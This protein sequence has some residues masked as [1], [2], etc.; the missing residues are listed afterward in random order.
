MTLH[1][2]DNRSS[3]KNL[4]ILLAI[5][6]LHAFWLLFSGLN[7]EASDDM[8]YIKNAIDLTRGSFTLTPHPFSNRFGAFVPLALYYKLFG[9]SPTTTLLAPM[10][11]SLILVATVFLVA[12]RIG[13]IHAAIWSAVLLA[14]NTNQLFF[15]LTVDDDI[16][17]STIMTVTAAWIFF[18]R[19]QG[20]GSAA[21]ARGA[22]VGIL[23]SL[24][25]LTKLS[26]TWMLP[27][28]IALLWHDLRHGRNRAFW[29][30]S[31]ISGT[32][33]GGMYLLVYKVITGDALYVMHGMQ[34][35]YDTNRHIGLP[36]VFKDKSLSQYMDRLTWEPVW[37]IAKRSGLAILLVLSLPALISLRCAGPGT[38]ALFPPGT[39]FWT[40]Y[41]FSVL[42]MFWFGTTSFSYY[43][44][45]G[46]SANYLLPTMGPLSLLAGV[47]LGRLHQAIDVTLDQTLIRR[48][49]FVLLLLLL[50]LALFQ[51]QI[52][53]YKKESLAA[54]MAVLLLTGA[55]MIRPLRLPA[56]ALLARGAVTVALLLFAILPQLALRNGEL[57]GEPMNRSERDLAQSF[58]SKI[59]RPTVI[60]TDRRSNKS[61]PYH[62]ALTLPSN[63]KLISYKNYAEIT[64]EPGTRYL[65]WINRDRF[66]TMNMNYGNAIPVFVKEPPSSWKLIAQQ[67]PIRIYELPEQ[68]PMSAFRRTPTP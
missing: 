66:R 59:D 1:S 26:V 61:I 51:A 19:N 52:N 20:E 14:F 68:D 29:L 17:V 23:F 3:L 63:I 56:A 42:G 58:L 40:A 25:V 53:W 44:P 31:F 67:D 13:G 21:F 12:R 2:T 47:V 65:A 39:R 18:Q 45:I 28:G 10:I 57:S 16:V 7:F 33:L 34:N 64:P 15:A 8:A 55:T 48:T 43:N 6:G 9:I 24:G 36:S 38:S 11:P 32:L 41:G 54:M 62:F 49:G 27:F 37:L 50:G 5:L 46:I 22:V 60:V 30:G 4:A 35:M